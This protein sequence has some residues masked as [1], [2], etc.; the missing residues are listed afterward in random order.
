MHFPPHW[1]RNLLNCQQ[2]HKQDV[3]VYLWGQYSP[4]K[5][6][7]IT[8]CTCREFSP[9]LL[10]QLPLLNVCASLC[11]FQSCAL[12]YVLR[13]CRGVLSYHSD[14][15][16]ALAVPAPVWFG[17]DGNV[18]GSAVWSRCETRMMMMMWTKMTTRTPR[19]PAPHPLSLASRVR[20]RSL[21]L[22][23]KTQVSTGFCY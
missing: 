7:F 5:N 6:G 9:G 8:L 13:V 18:C 19:P 10:C 2:V 12:M 16:P 11:M 23:L 3:F 14:R 4:K 17:S 22:K 15:N 21:T 1:M 20:R